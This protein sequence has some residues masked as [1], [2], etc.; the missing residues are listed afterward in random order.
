MLNCEKQLF[1]NFLNHGNLF[2]KKISMVNH[3]MFSPNKQ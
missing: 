1:F 3:A 2:K